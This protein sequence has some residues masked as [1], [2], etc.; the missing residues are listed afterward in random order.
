VPP[1]CTGRRMQTLAHPPR[2]CQTG[3]GASPDRSPGR[4]E[5]AGRAPTR[6][7]VRA[8]VGGSG[9][10][11]VVDPARP[12]LGRTVRGPLCSLAA[13]STGSS[14]VASHPAGPGPV[15]RYGPPAPRTVRPA[16]GA[17]VDRPERPLS[18]LGARP[19]WAPGR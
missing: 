13:P 19:R 7:S 12:G 15:G 14:P 2:Q 1:V 8:V 6:Q 9:P 4:G 10:G 5:T 3:S 18:A 11:R 17:F 16:P